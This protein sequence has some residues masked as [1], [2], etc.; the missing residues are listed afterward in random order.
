MMNRANLTNPGSQVAAKI[1]MRSCTRECSSFFPRAALTTWQDDRGDEGG[2]L[3]DV[4]RKAEAEVAEDAGVGEEAEEDEE[5]KEDEKAAKEE[6]DAA[7]EEA[8]E[9]GKTYKAGDAKA[10]LGTDGRRGRGA[11][12]ADGGR[13]GSSRGEGLAAAAA[14]SALTADE[15]RDREGGGGGDEAE[16]ALERDGGGG[17]DGGFGEPTNA[18]PT[19]SRRGDDLTA[20]PVVVVAAAVDVDD[21]RERKSGGEADA[22]EARERD[23]G[24]A[25]CDASRSRRPASLMVRAT[26]PGSACTNQRQ[27]R[28][29]GTLRVPGMVAANRGDGPNTLPP[30]GRVRTRSLPARDD[31]Q[32]CSFRRF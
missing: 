31:W 22:D 7:E 19:T 10:M 11:G 23:G 2:E 4:D 18:F 26:R 13:R 1:R 28:T 9:D 20:A 27:Q 15:A 6:A 25:S 30:R 29:P 5:D 12:G 21:A 16:E 24:G 32:L 17:G 3:V 8:A 14:V